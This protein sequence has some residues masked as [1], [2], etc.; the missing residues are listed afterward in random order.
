MIG[1]QIGKWTI[2]RKISQ[3]GMADVYL[4]ESE[5][6]FPGKPDRAAI[7]LLRLEDLENS[8]TL[9]ERFHREA[10]ILRSL[11]HDHI[12]QLFE[13]GEFQGRPYLIMEYVDGL[14]LDKVL[15]QRGKLT[16]EEVV[17]IGQMVAS[18]LKYAHRQE[19]IH[20]D[21]KPANLLANWERHV[22]LSD[23]GIARILHESRLTRENAIVGTANYVSPEQA[24]GKQATRKSDLYALGIILYELLTGRLPFEANTVAEILHKHRYAQF[25]ALSR[26]VETVPHDL[27]QLIASLLEK[28]PDKR[29]ANAQAVEETLLKLKRKFDRKRQ[30]TPK[31]VSP[32]TKVM[33]REEETSDDDLDRLREKIRKDRPTFPLLQAIVLLVGLAGVAGLWYWLRQPPSAESLKTTITRYLDDSDWNA[34]QSKLDLLVEQYPQALSSSEREELQAKITSI[35][36]Y[37]QA[38][39]QAGPFTFIPPKSEAERFYRRAVLAYYDGHIEEAKSIW[40]QI[41]ACFKDSSSQTAWVR[42]SEEALIQ[43]D[44]P[45]PWNLE[46]VLQTMGSLEGAE[47]ISKLTE[48]QQ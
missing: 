5:T 29:P 15:E 14:S 38:R 41:I 12:V 37:T 18:A 28:N 24:A 47:G 8:E 27:D 19:V 36:N 35:K 46:S 48:L 11:K 23:F 4:A 1:E 33:E 40:K 22:K 13:S 25:E 45:G 44:Q 20:R 9:L 32:A 31:P 3:G 30:Y 7:K 17:V 43:M 34:A 42:L 16:W 10:D 21:L 2:T 26:L 39:I 6:S